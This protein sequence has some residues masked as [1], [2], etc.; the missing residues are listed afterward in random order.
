MNNLAVAPGR[1]RK[2]KTILQILKFQY[3][4]QFLCNLGNTCNVELTAHTQNHCEINEEFYLKGVT[5]Y[6]R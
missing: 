1:S 4:G 5:G 6:V 2:V 3:F